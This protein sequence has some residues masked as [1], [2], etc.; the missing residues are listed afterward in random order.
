MIVPEDQRWNFCYIIPDPP[1]HPI[2]IVVPSSLQM[3]WRESPGY[4]CD[5][6][7]TVRNI[8]HDLL[9]QD[10]TVGR[11]ELEKHFMSHNELQLADIV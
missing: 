4:F 10:V 2:R 11:V 9:E 7:F 5:A 8:I 6:T 1:G 3:G